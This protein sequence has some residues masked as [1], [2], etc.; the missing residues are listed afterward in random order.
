MQSDRGITN[1][2]LAARFLGR[3]GEALI[4]LFLVN[5]LFGVLPLQLFNAGWQERFAYLFR[6]SSHFPLL[7]SALIFLCE[8]QARSVG[9]PFFPLRRIQ[10]LAPL[11]ALGFLLL[12]PVQINAIYTQIRDSDNQAQRTIR[13]VDRQVNTL[14]NV[15]NLDQL[16]QLMSRVSPDIPL[17]P[18]ES[19]VEIRARLVDRGETDLAR[20]RIAAN[21]AKRNA[22]KKAV[23]DCIRDAMICLIYAIAFYGVRTVD[24]SLLLSSIDKDDDQEK[25][26]L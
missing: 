1:R 24:K 11:A 7:G 22:I 20:L 17:Q 14:R 3:I 23:P 6:S 2:Y 26:I 15:N 10:N 25:F 8:S 19:I 4:F 16:Q 9:P 5:T 18:G 13:Q 12:I 21:N